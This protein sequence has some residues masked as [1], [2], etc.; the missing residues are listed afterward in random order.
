MELYQKYRPTVPDEILGNDIAIKSFR[1]EISKG[2]N[3]FLL[4]GPSGTGKTTLC[5][6]IANELGVGELNIHEYNSSENRGIDTVREIMEE[7]RYAPIGDGKVVYILDEYHMQTNAAQQAALKMLEE[8]PSWCIFMIANTN[9]EKVIDAIKTRCSRIEMKPL[10]N[11][12]MFKLLRVVAHKEE[13]QVD[14]DILKQIASIS[15][16]SSRMALKIL[17]S[18]LYLTND[19]ERKTFLKENVFS[20]ASEDSIELCR[21]LIKC[22]GWDRYAECMEK[23][24]DDV[25]SNPEGVRRLVMSYATS[26]LKK[27][28]NP[29][30]V[31]MLQAFSNADTYRNGVSA[32]WVGL[33]DFQDYLAQ[34]NG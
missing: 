32:I 4:T 5:R 11:V 30:A 20:D 24:K 6:C 28:M 12:T 8:C 31:A 27:G 18:V 15:E 14:P 17:G 16:G 21:A 7:L 13:I 2:H 33:L 26:V 10:D 23:I 3:V 22:E 9:P 29:V 19:E 25:S 1:S 34:L